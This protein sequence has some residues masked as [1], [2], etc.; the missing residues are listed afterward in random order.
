MLCLGKPC[1]LSTVTF[2]A[3]SCTCLSECIL[4]SD[5]AILRVIYVT[6][7]SSVEVIVLIS[8]DC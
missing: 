2:W 4:M 7:S 8:E 5:K 1:L 3:S 6:A